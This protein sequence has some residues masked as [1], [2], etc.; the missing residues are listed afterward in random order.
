MVES[1]DRRVVQS[2]THILGI[3]H[4]V[5]HRHCPFS[6]VSSSALF[7]VRQDFV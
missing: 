1:G 4:D 3:E 5:C 6:L 7:G 2:P